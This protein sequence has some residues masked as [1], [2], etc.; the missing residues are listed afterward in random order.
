MPH[1]RRENLKAISS[2]TYLDQ[3]YLTEFYLIDALGYY[4]RALAH[5]NEN[6]MDQTSVIHLN[7]AAALLALK[8]F[9]EAADQAK[10]A[11]DEGADKEKALYR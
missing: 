11:L 3:Q 8:H 5:S 2:C 7:M 10:K 6:A 9:P 4:Q 1:S